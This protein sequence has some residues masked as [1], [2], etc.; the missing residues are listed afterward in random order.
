MCR[1]KF[2]KNIQTKNYSFQ[3]F[4]FLTVILVRYDIIWIFTNFKYFFN[5]NELSLSFWNTNL[6]SEF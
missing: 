3:T 5:D 4:I 1:T 6:I 2:T